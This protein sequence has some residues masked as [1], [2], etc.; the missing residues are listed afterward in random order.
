MIRLIQ[1]IV[2]VDCV[3]QKKDF[4]TPFPLLFW[5]AFCDLGLAIRFMAIPGFN[6]LICGNLVCTRENS[7]KTFPDNFEKHKMMLLQM[8]RCAVCP[9][10]C[11][12]FFRFR[13]R[14]GFSATGWICTIQS[15]TRFRLLKLGIVCI[16]ATMC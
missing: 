10:Q 9:R 11:S 14:P 4:K 7:S 12:N 8:N 2:I 13:R 6:L 5:R 1:L 3:I 15:Q 16:N